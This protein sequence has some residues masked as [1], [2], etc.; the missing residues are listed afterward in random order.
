[1]ARIFLYLFLLFSFAGFADAREYVR[2]VGSSTVFPFMSAISEEFAKTY[3][4]KTPI[5]ES[6]GTSAGFKLFCT[7]VGDAHPDIVVSS[8]RMNEVELALCK[9]YSID[10]G[11]IMEIELGRD[12]LVVASSSG[13]GLD[14]EFSI[15]DIFEA[16]SFYVADGV[17]LVKNP[18]KRWG[19][20]DDGKFYDSEIKIYGPTR[21]TGTFESVK[22]MILLSQCLNE[23]AFNLAYGPEKLRKICSVVR[24]DGVYVEVSNN[25]NLMVQ[26]LVRNSNAFGL[27]SYSFFIRNSDALK[28][29]SVNGVRPTYESIMS[30]QYDFVRPVYL[31]LKLTHLGLVRGLKDLLNEVLSE[32]ALGTYG[33]LRAIG[34]VPMPDQE[35]GAAREKVAS[36]S[37]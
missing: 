29:H 13:S 16:I 1:M 14:Y 8:R 30:G 33:Y 28:A 21:N 12:A 37:S 25:E 19:N 26:K 9:V 17:R 15:R 5:V 24:D 34:M 32:N 36:L 31:Y 4:V 10:S 23:P 20:V 7:G 27:L 6:T 3:R 18:N 11:D 35:L 22:K 2:V